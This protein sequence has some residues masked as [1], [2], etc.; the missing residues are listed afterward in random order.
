MQKIHNMLFETADLVKNETAIITDE[1]SITFNKLMQRIKSISDFLILEGLTRGNKV[2]II[3]DHE[4]DLIATIYALMRIGGIAVPYLK[5][6]SIEE[7]KKDIQPIKPDMILS[8][9]KNILNKTILSDLTSCP[10]YNI[11]SAIEFQHHH[12]IEYLGNSNAISKLMELDKNDMV[13]Y[14]DVHSSNNCINPKC[15]RHSDFLSQISKNNLTDHGHCV[16]DNF[17]HGFLQT[18]AALIRGKTITIRRNR[19]QKN[20][21]IQVFDENNL[22][23]I[24]NNN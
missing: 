7:F 2:L 3:R 20:S 18:T 4:I 14:I 22:V 10:I 13:C 5:N 17:Y 16:N 12:N 11:E 8:S 6:P 23:C 9:K 1:S 21:L 19:L 24:T 15:Y